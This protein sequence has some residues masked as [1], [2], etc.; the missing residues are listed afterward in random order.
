MRWNILL[1]LPLILLLAVADHGWV[2]EWEQVLQAANKEGIVVVSSSPGT[3]IREVLTGP[4][5]K[6]FGIKVE[7]SGGPPA[8]L[9][10]RLKQE[11]D[12][13][14]YRWDVIVQ[15]TTTAIKDLKPIGALDPI[16]P[17]LILPE[18]KD[19]KNWLGGKLWFSEKDRLN[20]LM[21]LASRPGMA[22][23]TQLV[24]TEEFKSFKDLLQPKWAGKIVVG[25]DPRTTGSGQAQFLFFFMHK[26]LGPEYIRALLKQNLT[27]LPTDQQALDWLGH[28]KLPL[29]I[30]PPETGTQD[31]LLRG[32]P[33]A[34]IPPPQLKE[35]SYLSPGPASL[36]LVNKAPHPNAARVYINWLLSKEG[37][38]EYRRATDVPSLRTDM[39]PDNIPSWRRP[40]PG[41][42]EGYTEEAMTARD[43]LL[44]F[45]KELMGK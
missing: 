21:G 25:R 23:N 42:I 16:E 14:Q 30:G 10:A 37:Q 20:V 19:P 22:V 36:M 8:Q 5:E 29:L 12:A 28:G 1:V 34:L 45:L 41:Y 33:I 9:V 3:E 27:I 7:H 4:F 13:G 26:D 38:I 32:V 35:G 31:M 18:V 15:G 44:P 39:P 6:K 17:A 11:R 40:I 24:K 43:R 2:A